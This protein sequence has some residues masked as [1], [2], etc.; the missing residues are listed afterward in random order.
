MKYSYLDAVFNISHRAGT[1]APYVDIDRAKLVNLGPIALIDI[2]RLTSSSR[3]LIQEIHN[4]HLACLMYKII[5][6]SK[7]SDIYQLVSTEAMKLEK[8]N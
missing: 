5:S 3:K 2:Y 1:H 8:E 7:V 6:S 4:A